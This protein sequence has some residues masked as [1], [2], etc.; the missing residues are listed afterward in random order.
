MLGAFSANPRSSRP[1]PSASVAVRT[2]QAPE[3]LIRTLAGTALSVAADTM[4]E[5]HLLSAAFREKIQGAQYSALT[6]SVLGG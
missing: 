5:V 1:L 2:V 6:V 3:D 4:P